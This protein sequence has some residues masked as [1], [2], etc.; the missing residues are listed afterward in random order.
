MSND[1]TEYYLRSIDKDLKEINQTL[2]KLLS[3]LGSTRGKSVD[4]I[5][6]MVEEAEHM[7]HPKSAY[8][9]MRL[10]IDETERHRKR[11]QD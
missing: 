10:A 4:Q 2:M 5:P 6:K 7:E 11:E 1:R 3:L 8:D 9:Q